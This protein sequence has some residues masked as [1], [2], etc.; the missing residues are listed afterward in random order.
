[1]SRTL[2]SMSHNRRT[3][4]IVK[5]YSDGTSEERDYVPSERSK[6][7]VEILRE[8]RKTHPSEGARILKETL[9]RLDADMAARNAEKAKQPQTG[10]DGGLMVLIGLARLFMLR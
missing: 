8:R 9:D 2:T 6:R 7:A 10:G 1:M 4:K 5:H 3:N